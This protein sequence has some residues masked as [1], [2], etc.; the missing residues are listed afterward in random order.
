MRNGI[1][2]AISALLAIGAAISTPAG[3]APADQ[4]RPYSCRLLDDEQK[5][6]A[7]GACDARAG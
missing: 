2:V 6:C 7:F 4:A 1:K 3:A 5:K